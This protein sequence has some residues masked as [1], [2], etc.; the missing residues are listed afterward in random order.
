[1]T[2][3]TSHH[4]LMLQAHLLSLQ[5]DTAAEEERIRIKAQEEREQKLLQARPNPR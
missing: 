5:T 1:M 3:N 4:F 2:M